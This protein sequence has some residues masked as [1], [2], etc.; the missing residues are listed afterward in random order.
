MDFQCQ[1]YD[2]L[3]NAS[4]FNISQLQLCINLVGLCVLKRSLMLVML[5]KWKSFARILFGYGATFRENALVHYHDTFECACKN[6]DSGI[7]YRMEVSPNRIEKENTNTK[8]IE[9]TYSI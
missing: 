8:Y 7:S 5:N 9:N 4:R 3:V 6:F 1:F 2:I